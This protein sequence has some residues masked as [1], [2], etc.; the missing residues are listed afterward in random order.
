MYSSF[1]GEKLFDW[2]MFDLFEENLNLLMKTAGKIDNDSIEISFETSKENFII[3]GFEF[4]V[5][6][7]TFEDFHCFLTFII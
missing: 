4:N 3:Q 6:H 2:E 7:L 5:Y 1:G